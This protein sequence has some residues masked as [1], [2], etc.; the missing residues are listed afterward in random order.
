MLALSVAASVVAG[1]LRDALAGTA[2]GLIIA[3]PLVRLCWLM[4]RWRQEH[5]RRFV[6]AGLGVLAIVTAG[7]ALAATGLGR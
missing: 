5:D 2:I 3:A 4:H 7:A 6:L 1:P